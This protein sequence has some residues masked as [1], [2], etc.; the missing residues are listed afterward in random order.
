M[1]FCY[2]QLYV[3]Y[4]S[5]VQ[6]CFWYDKR[7]SYCITFAG[8]VGSSKTPIATFLSWSLGLPIVS[9]DTI[10]LEVM[11]DLLLFD[12]QEYERR[13][14]ARGK[15]IIS[16]GKPFIYDASIDREWPRLK[17][18]LTAGSY[19]SFIVSLD[20]SRTLLAKLYE[21]KGYHDTLD[22]LETLMHDHDRFL[23]QHGDVVNRH[24]DDQAFPKRLEISLQSASQWIS[25][26]A[27]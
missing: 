4:G 11:E 10:R 7:M 27:S 9:N 8:V 13:R 12:Q 15:Q 3:V 17:E 16:S 24:I 20:L 18:W 21:A 2:L 5:C 19:Q 14:D 22:R 26:S 6:R 25:R 23:D 1:I